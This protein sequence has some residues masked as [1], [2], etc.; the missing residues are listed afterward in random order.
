[1]KRNIIVL[2]LHININ[3]ISI[4]QN[5][6]SPF[7]KWIWRFLHFRYFEEYIQQYQEFVK[8]QRWYKS[9]IFSIKKKIVFTI[10]LNSSWAF[11]EPVVI[12]TS[13][14][15]RLIHHSLFVVHYVL[16]LVAG[17]FFFVLDLIFERCLVPKTFSLNWVIFLT[18]YSWYCLILL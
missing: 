8:I 18:A 16:S 2:R 4:P 10:K 1:M 9:K 12:F 6:S 7:S 17:L 3:K 11:S 5:V 15:F 13:L 14:L